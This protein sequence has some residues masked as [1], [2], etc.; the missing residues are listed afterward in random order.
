[1]R[2]R[3]SCA[4]LAAERISDLAVASSH[5]AREASRHLR[6]ASK[7]AASG[8]WH[9]KGSTDARARLQTRRTPCWLAGWLAGW[10]NYSRDHVAHHQQPPP[11]ERRTTTTGLLCALTST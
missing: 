7:R 6:Q 11:A 10:F 8:I 4:G 5:A 2:W 3:S 1:M 9:W